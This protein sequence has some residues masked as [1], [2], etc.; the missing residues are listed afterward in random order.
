MSLSGRFREVMEGDFPSRPV[1]AVRVGV[2]VAALLKGV[3]AWRRGLEVLGPE[4]LQVPWGGVGSWLPSGALP[5][6][7]GVWLAA[8]TAFVLGWRTRVAGGLLALS[9]ALYLLADRHLYQNHVYLLFLLVVLLTVARSADAF[10]MDAR[11][12]RDGPGAGGMVPR[13]PLDLLKLQVSL[14]Y[15]FAAV[16]KI[17]VDFLSGGTL[18]GAWRGTALGEFLVANFDRSFFMAAAGA[19]VV[20]EVWLALALW[21]PSR[22]SIAIG[23]GVLLHGGILLLVDARADLTV[24][25]LLMF[26]AYLLFLPAG[27]RSHLVIWDDHC[28]FCGGWVRRIRALDWLRVHRFAGSSEPGVLE[29]AGVSQEEAD[30]GLQH[31]GPE[32]RTQGYDAV[33]SALALLPAT[34]LVAP[35]MGLPGVKQVGRRIY[36]RVAERRHCMLPERPR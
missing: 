5:A 1:A 17:N 34:F 36:G 15:L 3:L 6:V 24:F 23:A 30:A 12:R 32:G 28:S 33:R 7:M 18:A 31:I 29:E 20:L 10:S 27:E 25:A 8:A 19:T 26:S 11:R 9:I 2:G 14:V 16:S 21:N 22:R 35:F 13:W 4:A